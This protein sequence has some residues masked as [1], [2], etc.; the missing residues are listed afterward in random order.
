MCDCV[1]FQT[2]IFENFSLPQN[3]SL[4]SIS[5]EIA[6]KSIPPG[7]AQLAHDLQRSPITVLSV[8]MLR[9][10]RLRAV[11]CGFPTE[12]FEKILRPQNF[13]FEIARDRAEI[14]AAW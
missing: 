11:F 9:H 4:R 1:R 5:R 3:L 7:G 10:V 2:E 14:R 12:I 6:P 13:A 8:R